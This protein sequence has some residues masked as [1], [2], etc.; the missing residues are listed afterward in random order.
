MKYK[1][2]QQVNNRTIIQYLYSTGKNEW[3]RVQCNSCLVVSP[4][5]LDG[6]AKRKRGC[7]HCHR[8]NYAQR[9]YGQIKAHNRLQAARKR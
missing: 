6:L 9:G 8:K 5:S 4:M 2:K 1:D 3:Y 7:I